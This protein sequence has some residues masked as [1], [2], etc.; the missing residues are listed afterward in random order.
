MASSS[1]QKLGE[2]S[3]DEPGSS[4]QWDAFKGRLHR[5]YSKGVNTVNLCSSLA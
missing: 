3:G 1:D 5:T 2:L 4:A